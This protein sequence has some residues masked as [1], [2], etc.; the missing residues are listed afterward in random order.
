MHAQRID[1]V[2]AKMLEALGDGGVRVQ[3]RRRA[4]PGT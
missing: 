4:A 3:R 1:D 2:R